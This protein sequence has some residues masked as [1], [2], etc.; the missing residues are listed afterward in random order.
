MKDLWRKSCNVPIMS[1]VQSGRKYSVNTH[2]FL[3][4]LEGPIY[5]GQRA[6]CQPKIFGNVECQLE[7]VNLILASVSSVALKN[8]P[9]S[10]HAVRGEPK[11][12]CVR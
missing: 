5:R 11:F 8:M 10:L 7:N 4:P 9:V 3:A 2:G 6:G 1:K 12:F